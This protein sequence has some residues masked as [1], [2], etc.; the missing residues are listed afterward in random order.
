M[1]CRQEPTHYAHKH[2]KRNKRSKITRDVRNMLNNTENICHQSAKYIV[3]GN[4]V[5][6]QND[7]FGWYL[8]HSR[9]LIENPQHI[10]EG[11][12]QPIT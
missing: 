4:S 6:N 10:G 9:M 8:R 12:Y 5:G 11:G 2:F 1:E 7:Y 3:H